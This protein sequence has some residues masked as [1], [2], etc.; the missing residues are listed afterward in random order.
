MWLIILNS[1]LTLT[2]FFVPSPGVFFAFVIFNG[3]AQAIVGAYLQTSTIAVASLFGPPAVQA[4]MAG[5][6][7]VAVAVSGVQVVS[8][9]ASVWGKP[10]TFASDGSAEERSAFV[11]FFLS[12]LFL[13][14]CGAAHA[15]L[16]KM[17]AYH[18]VAAALERGAKKYHNEDGHAREHWGLISSEPT[19]SSDVDKANYF[20]IAKLNMPFEIGA[21][22]VF[23]VTLVCVSL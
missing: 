23:V 17:P 3:S 16:V 22:Y 2:T 20:R 14:V 1:L 11:F 10:S 4:M 15:W 19:R 9:A 21:A 7:A 5:Q 13:L 6:A 18:T 8:A 12:T